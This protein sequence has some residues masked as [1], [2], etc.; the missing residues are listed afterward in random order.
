[1]DSP[2]PP[3]VS[4]APKKSGLSTGCIVALVLG[5]IAVAGI[6]VI[7][8]LAALAIPTYAKVQEKAKQIQT[9]VEAQTLVV[10]LKG[11]HTEYGGFP[12]PDGE[13]SALPSEGKWLEAQLAHDADLNP[14]KIQFSQY[15]P[16][17]P[18]RAGLDTS[19]TRALV[20]SWGNRYRVLMDTNGDGKVPDPEHTGASLSET[21]A[22]WSA[23]PDGD[24]NTWK[25]NVKSWK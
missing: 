16:S 19:S 12:V 21:V 13:G 23:G 2:P 3:P 10:S 7:G 14:R 1:M 22:V 9:L 6:G 20:D 25:D 15:P 24:F 8:I 11:F 4:S 18:G 5:I 17:K